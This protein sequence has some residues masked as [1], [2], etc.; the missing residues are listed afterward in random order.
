MQKELSIFEPRL[1][2]VSKTKPKD[3]IIAAYDA[4]QRNFG[5]NYVQELVEKANDPEILEKCREIRWHFIG[6]L[7]RNKVN[8]IINIPGLYMV[9]TVDSEKLANSINDQYGKL[10]YGDLLNVMV[11]VNTSG[12]EGKSGCTPQEA[13]ALAKHILEKCKHLNFFGLMSIGIFGYDNSLGPNPDFQSLRNCREKVCQELG[14]TVSQVELSMGMSDDFEH[15]IEMGS[16]NIRVGSSIFGHRPPKELPPT[17]ALCKAVED[18][19]LDNN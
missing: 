2:A 13:P 15:A 6:H 11:Q 7:Q 19:K 10:G 16:S 9:E 3:L 12:E 18:V 4:G 17:E 8:K 14:L 5:E 1:V